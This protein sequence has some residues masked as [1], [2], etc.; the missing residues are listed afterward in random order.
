MK[1]LLT[2]ATIL[3]IKYFNEAG[4][5]LYPVGG[6]VRN[7][8]LGIPIND[9]DMCTNATPTQMQA[10]AKQYDLK[11]IPTGI[12]HGTM[13]FI[14][15]E[16][17]IEI[18]TFRSEATYVNHRYPSDVSFS[19]TLEEDVKRRDFTINAL[20]YD[21]GTILD[22]HHG[23][24]DLNNKIV[25]CISNPDTRFNEDA[26]RIL[27]ALRFSMQ[28][29][30]KIEE[31]TYQSI[32][33]NASLLQYISKERIKEEFNKMLL[34]THQSVFTTLYDSHVLPYIL[35]K[36]IDRNTCI[37][38]DKLLNKQTLDLVSQLALIQFQLSLHNEYK[39]LTYSNKQ[40]H[41]IYT[42]Y[43][44]LNIPL[45]TH[46]DVRCILYELQGNEIAF[47]KYVYT[48]SCIV[49]IDTIQ[50]LSYAH[51]SI[52]NN[53]CFTLSQLCVQA[54]DLMEIGIQ[55]KQIGQTLNYL[56]EYVVVHQDKNNKAF[57]LT[58]VKGEQDEICNRK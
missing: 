24:Q 31:N 2:K 12:K 26:L 49:D 7:Y 13:S 45:V 5:E 3:L 18:T 34:S 56:L 35:D 16:E 48:K 55:G 27:R 19:N 37:L 33:D 43:K 41:E 36:N 10:I 44:L 9:I 58:L 30:F 39:K 15:H 21:N 6:C 54:K 29:Q 23:L 38:L 17:T 53:E 28:L 40:I 14:L 25:R 50:I 57:L 32:I 8:I 51:T 42:I 47:E 20:A 46:R 1:Q 11:I 52:D 22:Y 4:Y